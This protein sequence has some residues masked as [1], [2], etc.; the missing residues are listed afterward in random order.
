MLN[1]LKEVISNKIMKI[2]YVSGIL[3]IHDKRFLDKFIENGYETHVVS[4]SENTLEPREGI[5]FHH[6]YLK[7][8][9]L[10]KNVILLRY[11]F[12]LWRTYKQISMLKNLLKQIKPDILH[13][14]WI[15]VDGFFSALSGLK[16]FILIP[17]GSDIL[18]LPKNSFMWK[19]VT[20]YTIKKSTMII[21]DCEYVKKEIIKISNY[22]EN[23]IIVF[24]FGIDLNK[25]N[26][27]VNG[28][29]IRRKLG[30]LDKKIVIIASSLSPVYGIEFFL[31]ALE[32]IIRLEK[33][34][35]V[36]ICGQGPLKSDFEDFIK[37]HNLAN[38]VFF[39]GTIPNDEMPAYYNAADIYMAPSLNAGT[40]LSLLEAMACG[41]P[42]IVSDIPS[43]MEWIKDG[44]NGYV[45]PKQDTVLLA[46]KT[47]TLL[48]DR[49]LREDFGLINAK[50]AQERANWNNNFQILQSLY[51][52][53]INR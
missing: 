22:P 49:P 7:S 38:N 48:K 44:Y 50:I 23:K 37:K 43:N 2:C 8:T 5:Y 36:V 4:F 13:G 24:P 34:V 35:R 42:V 14:G 27:A 20:K 33:D 9:N 18:I 10:F 12:F 52:T 15:P 41:L 29:D 6:F 30:W 19:I 11:I 31:R 32:E 46:H 51:S 25:F 1:G 40:S 39:A 3:S 16:P 45:V 28:Q 17:W 47:I 21:C 26:T 53:L